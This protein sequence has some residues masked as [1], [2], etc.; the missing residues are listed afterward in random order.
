[1]GGILIPRALPAP[2][3]RSRTAVSHAACDG[4]LTIL[5]PFTRNVAV[6]HV[7]LRALPDAVALP[8]AG[9][10]SAPGQRLYA[11]RFLLDRQRQFD[12]DARHLKA[13]L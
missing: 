8:W 2:F 6:L 7:P 10:T 5:F 13:G 1:M 12:N 4:P 9:E 3:A 11:H